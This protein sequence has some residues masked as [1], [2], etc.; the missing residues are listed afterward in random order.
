MIPI[1]GRAVVYGE[2]WFDEAPVAAVGVD[3]VVHR[4]R[5]A[6]IP[7]SRSVAFLS[8]H[9]DLAPAE[10]AILQQFQENCRYQIRRAET[11]DG[12]RHEFIT[13]TEGRLDEFSA[14]YDAFAKQKAVWLADRAWLAAASRGRQL[15]LTAAWRADEILVRHAYLVAGGIARL[16]YSGSCFRDKGP[17]Y[18][19]LVG[20]A[21]R[22]LHWN[23]MLRL[24]KM[25]VAQYDWGGMFEDE[26]T[27]E[28]EGINRFKRSFG[29]QPVR[30]YDCT[31]PATLRGRIWL[32]VRDAWRRLRNTRK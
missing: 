18:R 24:K 26:T 20:R 10:N 11:K 3:I 30:R 29:G 8:L 4:Q 5:S 31:V 9:T 15:I 28:R 6:P 13:D 7:D 14:F 16:E 19:S 12:L 32:P 22:W 17:G 23:D 2:V 27:P 21:N 25:D 1:R